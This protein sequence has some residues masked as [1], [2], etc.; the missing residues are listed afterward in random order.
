MSSIWVVARRLAATAT[1]CLMP[2]TVEA[3]SRHTPTGPEPARVLAGLSTMQAALGEEYALRNTETATIGN[4]GLTLRFDRVT[5]DARCPV[6]DRCGA[7][8]GDAVVEVTLHQDPHEA[9]TLELHTNAQQPREAT[10]RNYRV[11]LIRLEPRPIGEQPVPLPRY[12][13]TFVVSA[14]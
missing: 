12:T 6:G 2:M 8:E 10:Y 3:C 5:D 9:V 11:Q 7:D 4:D 13:G 1:L 14:R